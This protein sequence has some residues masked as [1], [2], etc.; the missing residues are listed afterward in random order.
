MTTLVE[1]KT[2]QTDIPAVTLQVAFESAWKQ[3]IKQLKSY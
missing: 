1:E 2:K 3:V